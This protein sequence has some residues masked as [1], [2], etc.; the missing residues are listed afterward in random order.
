MSDLRSQLTSIYQQR[1]ELTPQSVVDEAR[2]DEHPLHHRFEWDDAVAGEAYRRVQASELIRSVK[3]VY[4]ETPA[5]ERKSIRAFSS[6][7]QADDPERRGYAPTE[8]LVENELTRA[9][10]LR[11]LEREIGSLKRKYGHLR[12]FSDVMSKA[13]AS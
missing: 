5:G 13:V 12:E 7:S 2:P 8:E 9:I 11:N 3:V 6:L 10:L 1:G 4:N